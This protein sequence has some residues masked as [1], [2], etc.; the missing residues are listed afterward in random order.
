MRIPR[1]TPISNRTIQLIIGECIDGLEE[2]KE[3]LSIY[4]VVYIDRVLA[5][6]KILSERRFNQL[7]QEDNHV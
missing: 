6:L 7:I 5:K 4:N 1:H 3:Y 2:V